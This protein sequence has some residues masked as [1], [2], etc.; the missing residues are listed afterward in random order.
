LRDSGIKGEVPVTAEKGDVVL[1]FPNRY[2]WFPM[3]ITGF[4]GWG[5]RMP[6]AR[7][8]S[9]FSSSAERGC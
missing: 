1:S 4:W 9:L 3:G 6:Q 5:D 8:T 7:K 2:L